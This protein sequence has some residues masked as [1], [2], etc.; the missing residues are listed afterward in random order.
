M[1]WWPSALISGPNGCV[2]D[3]RM[4]QTAHLGLGHFN[5][6]TLEVNLILKLKHLKICRKAFQ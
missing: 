6:R 4:L 5:T 3:G 2:P 1:G